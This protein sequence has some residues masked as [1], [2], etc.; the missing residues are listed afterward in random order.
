MA[1]KRMTRRTAATSAALGLAVAG[2][3]LVASPANASTAFSNRDG[4]VYGTITHNSPYQITVS[5]YIYGNADRPGY[6]VLGQ[7]SDGLGL[8]TCYWGPIRTNSVDDGRAHKFHDIVTCPGGDAVGRVVIVY[9][10]NGSP[11]G[12]GSYG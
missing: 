1:L 11:T 12:E 7:M 4:S 10:L 2:S 9:Y 3:L 5:G 6:E 8:R